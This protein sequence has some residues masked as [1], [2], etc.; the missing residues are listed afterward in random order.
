[1]PRRRPSR[2]VLACAVVVGA[3]TL[4]ASCR[5]GRDFPEATLP[6]VST[7]AI[8]S[9]TTTSTTTTSTLP[10]TTTTTIVVEG[11]TV[12][13]ANASNVNGAAGR[14]ST[15][16]AA[17][18]FTTGEPTNGWGPWNELDVTTVYFAPGG[19]AVGASVALLMGVEAVRMPTPVW[20][21]GGTETLKGA[22]VLVML[23]KDRAS[24]L[25]EDMGT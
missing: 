17:L 12:V 3:A 8:D 19:E 23:G 1:M 2:S 5:T 20:I 4:L 15:E 6:P 11:A 16:L 13:V 9:T 22:T 7:E 24:T 14:L 25:L 18:S 21:T 10:P